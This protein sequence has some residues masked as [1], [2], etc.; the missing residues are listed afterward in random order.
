[1][2]TIDHAALRALA[3]KAAN[4]NKNPAFNP[5]WPQ[6][7]EAAHPGTVLALLDEIV[8]LREALL[9]LVHVAA[10]ADELGDHSAVANWAR[11]ARAALEPRT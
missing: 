2:S 4:A 10:E 1:M 7:A 5:F 8:R 3:E 9:P 11:I 6:F